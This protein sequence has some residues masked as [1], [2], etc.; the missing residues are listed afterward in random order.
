MS[1]QKFSFIP[2]ARLLLQLGDQLIR[3]E[4]VAIFE[5]VKNCYDANANHASVSFTNIDNPALGIIIIEDDGDGMDL[6]IIKNVWMQP[7]TDYKEKIFE[8]HKDDDR[9]KKRLPIGEKGIGRFG[10]YKLGNTIELITKRENA[11][12]EIYFKIDWSNL[13]DVDYLT[14]ITVEVFERT[15]KHFLG[16]GKGTRI[17]IRNLRNTWSRKTF[18]DTV[19]LINTLT[20]PHQISSIDSF[21]VNVDENMGWVKGILDASEIIKKAIFRGKFTIKNNVIVDFRYKFSPWDS[22]LEMRSRSHHDENIKMREQV[23]EEGS[24]KKTFKEIDLSLFNIGEI[25]VYFYAYTFETSILKLEVEDKQG[26]KNYVTANSGV[27][28]YRD[29]MRVYDYGEKSNDWLGLDIRRVNKPGIKISNNQLIGYVLLKRAQSADLIEKS[30]REGFIEDEAYAVFEKAVSFALQQF[31]NQRNLDKTKLNEKYV[32]KATKEPVVRR[33]SDLKET[34]EVKVKD[35]VVRKDL[36]R[37]IARIEE[38]YNEMVETFIKSANAGISLGVAVHE[39]DK[40]VDELNRSL[41]NRTEKAINHARDLAKRLAE[42]VKGYSLLLHSKDTGIYDIKL[43][44][45]QAL[46]NVDFRLRAHGIELI[47]NINEYPSS[48]LKCSRSIS[49]GAITNL[50]DNSIWWLGYEEIKNKKS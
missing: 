46:F 18:R 22:M 40:V 5:L 39:I 27:K 49:I 8:N 37:E 44:V 50:I 31:E 35:E 28:V 20:T 43:I 2:R 11:A 4:A 21:R 3:N 33:L 14:D 41:D 7:G 17:E 30:N 15:P 9:Y 42:L 48:K 23:I 45:K 24:P 19:R 34:I 26:F 12:N 1:K 6:D 36:E 16:N 25:R 38:E 47:T 32:S 13:L 29:G 10:A